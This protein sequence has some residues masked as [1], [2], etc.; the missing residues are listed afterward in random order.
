MLTEK[1]SNS[2]ICNH[3]HSSII[4]IQHTIA[5]NSPCSIVFSSKW[6]LAHHSTSILFSLLYVKNCVNIKLI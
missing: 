4:V 6:F 5:Q 3:L 2:T 1:G